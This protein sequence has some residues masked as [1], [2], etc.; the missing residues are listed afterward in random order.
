MF[1]FHGAYSDPLPDFYHSIAEEICKV[2]PDE[3]K[4]ILVDDATLLSSP[5]L[6]HRDLFP[7]L[8][9]E[10]AYWGSPPDSETAIEELERL[11]WAGAR[12][13]VFCEPSFWWL[14]YY[15]EFESYLRSHYHCVSEGQ[16]LI[17]FDLTQQCAGDGKRHK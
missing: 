3:C 12:Y 4:F 5:Q 14:D 7:F 11:L 2:I 10:G 9:H 16:K 1:E 15:N 8:E 17:L 13:I 6:S